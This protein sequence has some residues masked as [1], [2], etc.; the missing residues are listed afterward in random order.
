MFLTD[1]KV[2]ENKNIGANNYLLKFKIYDED[3]KVLEN[4]KAGQ[5]FMLK[6]PL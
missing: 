2:I 3:K 5:F 1:C 6:C 4:S